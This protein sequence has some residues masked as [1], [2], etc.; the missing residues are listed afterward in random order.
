MSWAFH[1]TL[2]VREAPRGEI[3]GGV[4]GSEVAITTRQGYGISEN[5]ATDSVSCEEK[6]SPQGR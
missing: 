2:T 6:L 1:I 4:I 5:G 3:V